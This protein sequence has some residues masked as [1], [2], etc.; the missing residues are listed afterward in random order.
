[1]PPG[2]LS[3]FLKYLHIIRFFQIH[4]DTKNISTVF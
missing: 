2:T 3:L 1:M 4:I